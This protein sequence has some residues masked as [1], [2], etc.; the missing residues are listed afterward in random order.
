M[1]KLNEQDNDSREERYGGD[2]SDGWWSPPDL[3]ALRQLRDQATDV[4]KSLVI[5]SGFNDEVS[6]IDGSA[7]T[8]CDHGLKLPEVTQNK[9]QIML[10]R[11]RATFLNQESITDEVA[12]KNIIA[13]YVINHHVIGQEEIDRLLAEFALSLDPDLYA[14]NVIGSVIQ[15]YQEIKQKGDPYHLGLI[16]ADLLEIMPTELAALLLK[17]IADPEV[18]NQIKQREAGLVNI[19]GLDLQPYYIEIFALLPTEIRHNILKKL[20]ELGYRKEALKLW[21]KVAA[22]SIERINSPYSVITLI[23]HN[24]PEEIADEWIAELRKDMGTWPKLTK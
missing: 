24:L 9:L 22:N 4:E 7:A 20:V 11:L 3:A 23:R 1:G 10:A 18:T 12:T 16:L 21:R 17:G 15:A 14:A 8:A 5:I 19:E 6:L 13:H 2:V